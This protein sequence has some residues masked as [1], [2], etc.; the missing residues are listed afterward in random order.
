LVSPF[1]YFPFYTS[2]LLVVTS[3]HFNVSCSCLYRKY[4][5]HTCSLSF[6]HLSSTLTTALPLA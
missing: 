2:L 3:T 4:I 6:L 1:Y 5:I